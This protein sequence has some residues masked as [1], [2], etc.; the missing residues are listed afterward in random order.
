ML[1]G[2]HMHAMD[3]A[4][5][6]QKRERLH[7]ALRAAHAEFEQRVLSARPHSFFAGMAAGLGLFIC[8]RSFTPVVELVFATLMNHLLIEHSPKDRGSATTMSPR[9]STAAHES[10]QMSN[11]LM[12]GRISSSQPTSDWP[13][14][15]NLRRG[16]LDQSCG[17]LGADRAVRW[18]PDA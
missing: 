10:P 17:K 1:A 4:E 8:F 14:R 12:D 18:L 3:Q 16:K 7:A 9:R 5:A 11:L 2:V 13:V 6:V 15:G